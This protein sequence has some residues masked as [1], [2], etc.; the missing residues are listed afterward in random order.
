MLN[1]ICYA[2]D[3]LLRRS[4]LDQEL[5]EEIAHHVSL[6]TQRN[7]ERGMPA[8]EAR[9]RALVA[10]GGAER[11]KEAHRDARGTRW[12]DD[13]VADTRFATRALRRNPALTLA[14]I[15]TLALVIGANTAIF[16]AVNGT[17]I[18]PLPFG[19][20]DRLVMVGENNREFLWHMADAAPANYLD[21]RARVPAFRDAMAYADFPNS[22]TLIIDGRPQLAPMALVTGNFFSVLGV[23]AQLGRTFRDEETWSGVAPVV[24]VSERLWRQ[25]LGANPAVVGTSLAVGGKAATIVGVAP[26]GFNFPRQ[27]VDVWVPI[28]WSKD[29]TTLV[30]FRRAHWLRVIARLQPGV[31]VEQASAQLRDV[32]RQLKAEY[33]VTNRIMDAELAPLQR[34]LVGDTRLSLL[35]LLGAVGLLLLIAC[36][37]VASLQLVRAAN[38]HREVSV[39]VALGAGRLRLARQA[40]TES[41]VLSVVGTALGLALGWV[42]TRFLVAMQP[43]DGSMLPVDGFHMDWHVAAFA[44]LV[45]A[46]CGLI[47]GLAPA[48]W[49]SRRAPNEALASGGRGGS[50]GIR[51]R[52]WSEKLA[53]LEVAIALALA[54]GAGLLVRSYG[55][56]LDV[57]PG[58]DARNVLAT[59]IELP[60]TRYGTSAATTQFFQTVVERVRAIPGVVSAGVV[61]QLPLTAPGWSSDF[62]IDGASAGHFSATLLHRQAAADYFV[63]MR[64]PLI[65]GRIFTD[66]DR[67]P[68]YV[69]VINDELARTYFRGQDPVGQRIT[70]DRTPDST[71]TWRTIIGVVGSEHQVSPAAPPGIE[72][73]APFAQESSRLMSIVARTRGEPMAVA[74]AVRRIVAELDPQLAIANMRRMTDVRAASLSHDRFLMT[75]L[76][77]FGVLGVVLAIVGVYGVVAQ[78]ARSRLR[79]MGIRIALGARGR[80]IQWLIVRRGLVIATIGVAIGAVGSAFGARVLERLLYSVAP[81]DATTLTSVVIALIVAALVASWIPA[82]RAGKVDPVTI[83]R[84]E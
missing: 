15:A 80:S 14:A 66:G 78:L 69:V 10:F 26:R 82:M 63:T 67:G 28:G 34:F 44:I 50:H 2:V 37:N 24:V 54:V 79:E 45:A 17:L 7:I 40:I 1:R 61:T 84:E 68:P 31:R 60:P 5:D 74:P 59:T 56:L 62:S 16:S 13:L 20:P 39:R 19:E 47:F 42:G 76:S 3:A 55:R 27:D 49:S 71:S 22:V 30:S 29:Q 12:L 38:R 51:V 25:Q 9:R 83:L 41:L 6:E 77:I 23:G 52:G 48:I 32:A 70:F 46:G 33:P 43:T 65:R 75:L 72:A 81:T 8:G 35:I 11:L 58:F 57:D 64:V 4:H 36:A 53:V 73:I 21:W 18:R